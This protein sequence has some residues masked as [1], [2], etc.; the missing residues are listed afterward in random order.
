MSGPKRRGWW[1]GLVLGCLA[2][3]VVGLVA[4]AQGP[5]ATAKPHASASPSASASAPS[6]AASAAPAAGE[7]LGQ[8]RVASLTPEAGMRGWEVFL[9]KGCIRCHSV[10]GQGGQIGPDLGRSRLGRLSEGELMVEL[11]NSIPRMWAK[12]EEEKIPFVAISKEEMGD[13]FSFLFFLRYMDKEGD[14][15]QGRLAMAHYRC[16]ECHTLSGEGGKVG[17]DLAHWAE[18]TNPVVWTQKMWRAAPEMTKA[19]E[20]KDMKWPTFQP[21]DMVNMIAYVRSVSTSREKIS[22]G[23]GS[24][25]LGAELTKT[26]NCVA[27]HG[28]GGS[29][30]D[31]ADLDIPADPAEAAVQFLNHAPQ[32]LEEMKKLGIE[33]VKLESQELAHVLAYLLSLKYLDRPGDPARGRALFTSAGCIN[34]HGKGTESAPEL[35]KMHPEGSVT[36]L[37]HALWNKGHHMLKEMTAQGNS[38]PNFTRKEMLDLLAFLREQH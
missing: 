32:M 11:W 12:M 6:P 24:P 14:P 13:L 30:P 5:H 1:M 9:S 8:G 34:C 33:P 25:S 20:A 23:L 18:F 26:K 22:L 37:S 7:E 29:A 17:P 10:W 19:M 15:R 28:K 2:T 35:A 31:L 38:W 4:H 21:G 16:Q 36:Y 27:C 3:A